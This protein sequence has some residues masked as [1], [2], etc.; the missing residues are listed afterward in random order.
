MPWVAVPKRGRRP[1]AFSRWREGRGET[2]LG[3]TVGLAALGV[4]LAL[5]FLLA[6]GVA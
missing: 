5:L 6:H 2:L 4:L 3:W 1:G